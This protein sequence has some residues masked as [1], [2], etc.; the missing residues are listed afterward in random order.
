V[1]AD[2]FVAT[3][4]S[5]LAAESLCFGALPLV[6]EKLDDET[7]HP[8]AAWACLL[9]TH[10]CVYWVVVAAEELPVHLRNTPSS[11]SPPSED[12]LTVQ[13]SSNALV[14]A[15]RPLGWLVEVVT[16]DDLPVRPH[17]SPT[18]VPEATKNSPAVQV[19]PHALV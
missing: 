13:V 11:A 8:V 6:P 9:L 17:M 3:I 10:V 14:F 18:A 19:K 12:A 7:L 15:P 2:R 1:P 16:L 5:I 4:A